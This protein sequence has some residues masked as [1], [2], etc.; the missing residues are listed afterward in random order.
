MTVAVATTRADI[1]FLQGCADGDLQA[2][3]SALLADANP[4]ATSQNMTGL[5]KAIL[6]IAH[7]WPESRELLET[8][9]GVGLSLNRNNALDDMHGTPLHRLG[10]NMVDFVAFGSVSN[11]ASFLR[12]AVTYY[13]ADLSVIRT[14]ASDQPM[15]RS[16]LG[17]FMKNAHRYETAM[18][19]LL[20]LA[21]DRSEEQELEL[22][23]IW[24]DL[25]FSQGARSSLQGWLSAGILGVELD[26]EWCSRLGKDEVFSLA[27]TWAEQNP[28]LEPASL[29]GKAE[30]FEVKLSPL[31]LVNTDEETTYQSSPLLNPQNWKRM[32]ELLAAC[33]VVGE[34]VT[35]ADLFEPRLAGKNMLEIGVSMACQPAKVLEICAQLGVR[36]GAKELLN[37]DKTPNA[38]LTAFIDLQAAPLLFAK[39]HWLGKRGG[40][41]LAVYNA[42]PEIAKQQV[43]NAHQL[44]AVM[45][46]SVVVPGGIA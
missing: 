24:S 10:W 28:E 29:Q 22:V 43:G 12:E 9:L 30:L 3:K 17:E 42:L 16:V 37:D 11:V 45:A 23:K 40:E 32:S 18:K 41:F 5:H 8:L 38:L 35:E 46:K 6:L 4:E 1:D 15:R 21:P 2:V 19:T 34:P 27:H 25:V 20:S 44:L 14:G 13:G 26:K 7:R 33:E 36:L 39:E 31:A